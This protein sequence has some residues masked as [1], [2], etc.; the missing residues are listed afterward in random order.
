M[1]SAVYRA[2]V[3]LIQRQIPD[4]WLTADEGGLAPPAA[5][6]E[7]LFVDAVESIRDA[8]LQ[9]GVDVCLAF[10]VA[11]SHFWH[12]GRYLAWA[13]EP[14]T[15]AQMINALAGWVQRYPIVSIE[16]GLAED[17]W[18]HWPELRETL[19][20]R[21]SCWAMTCCVPTRNGSP[22]LWTAK[23]ATPCC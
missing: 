13:A 9:P 12:D 5:N 4:A 7:Q 2:A 11:S 14:L 8:G 18:E 20:G 19:G 3:R 17:D 21:F 22:G 16:D 10:D 1:A 15:A 23:R 6:P